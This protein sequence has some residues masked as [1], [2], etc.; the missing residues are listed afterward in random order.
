[1]K[2]TDRE[3]K[4]Q[5]EQEQEQ[6]RTTKRKK[7]KEQ[8]QNSILHFLTSALCTLSVSVSIGVR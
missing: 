8:K 3:Q 6:R 4:Q 7:T 5:Q 2:M 1:M